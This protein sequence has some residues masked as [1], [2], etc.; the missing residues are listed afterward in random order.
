[1]GTDHRAYR[2]SVLLILPHLTTG[3][4]V[5]AVLGDLSPCTQWGSREEGDDS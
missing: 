1:M 4:T 3:A 2:P 5:K